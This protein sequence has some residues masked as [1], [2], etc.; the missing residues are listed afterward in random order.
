MS[1]SWGYLGTLENKFP[2]FA[3]NYNWAHDIDPHIFE[4]IVD[5]LTSGP[6]IAVAVAMVGL[7]FIVG[8]VM[9]ILYLISVASLIEGVVRVENGDSFKLI[10]LF[11]AGVRHIWSFLGLFFITLIS[12]GIYFAMLGISLILLLIALELFGLIFLIFIF[13]LAFIGIFLLS[14]L[15][16]L[17]QREIVI[18]G[19]SVFEAISIAFQLLKNNVGSNIIIFLITTFLWMIIV[20][21]GLILALIFAI[22]ALIIGAWSPVFMIIALVVILPVLLLIAIVVEG[23]LGTFFNSL[24]TYFYLELTQNSIS[25]N[26]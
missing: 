24:F 14:N 10:E 1:A 7:F 20:L 21:C 18:N 23:F 26:N 11:K 15:Y 16:S 6:G 25:S 5:W 19:A 17:A 8:L 9:F 22:P 3:K 13:P 12:G 2:D 4:D